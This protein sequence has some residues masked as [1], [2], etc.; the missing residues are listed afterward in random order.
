MDNMHKKGV[1]HRDI[2]PENLMLS[3]DLT[4]MKLIDFG[5]SCRK[6]H[7]ATEEERKK[8]FTT[9]VGT[10]MWQTPEQLEKHKTGYTERSDY[11][12]IGLTIQFAITGREP[13]ERLQDWA[14]C[15]IPE[16]TGGGCSF[17]Y[18]MHP[19]MVKCIAKE[20]K[21]RPADIREIRRTVHANLLEAADNTKNESAAIECVERNDDF[22]VNYIHEELAGYSSLH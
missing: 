15:A 7:K 6:F 21:D 11:Y 9:A 17:T 19:I 4:Q 13:F 20:D 16:R 22:D 8:F 1:Y 10:I 12:A 3:K 2:K 5:I 18:L 14:T